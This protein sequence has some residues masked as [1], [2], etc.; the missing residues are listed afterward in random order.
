MCCCRA[1]CC[2][3]LLTL[4]AATAITAHKGSSL[5]VLK[6]YWQ[7]LQNLLDTGQGGAAMTQKSPSVILQRHHP[8]SEL[9]W[10]VLIR[11]C[12]QAVRYGGHWFVKALL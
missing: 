5:H 1:A 3:V 6:V 8:I 2:T 12:T 9:H 10:V 11:H 4:T 7:S